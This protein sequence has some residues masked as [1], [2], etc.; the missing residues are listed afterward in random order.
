[1]SMP[2]CQAKCDALPGCTAITTRAHAPGLVDCYRKADVVPS[3]CD[4]GTSF[5]TYLRPPSS[6]RA[7]IAADE[8]P[9]FNVVANGNNID[10]LVPAPK[11]NGTGVV[12]LGEVDG[13]DACAALCVKRLGAASTTGVGGCTAFT[14]HSPAFDGPSWRR[15]CYGTT[16]GTWNPQGQRNITSGQSDPT[17]TRSPCETDDDCSR[18]GV[19]GRDGRCDCEP[20]WVGRFCTQLN[21]VPTAPGAGLHRH[22]DGQQVSTWGGSVLWDEDSKLWHSWNAEMVDFCGIRVWLTN[23]AIR[24]ATTASLDEP[25]E[26]KE[27]VWPVFAHEPTVAR[28]PTGE[29]VMFFTAVFAP[30]VPCTNRTCAGGV[31]GSTPW[32]HPFPG[33]CPN[34]Q[35]CDVNVPL[36]SY[37]SYS[38]GPDGPWS[39]PQILPAPGGGDTNL[40]PIIRKDGSL[41]GLGRPPFVWRSPDWKN[42]S[43]Y[44]FE[45][46]L[47]PLKNEDP[48][49]FVK[50]GD[51]SILHAVFH[52]GGWESPFG[53]HFW[54]T[55]DGHSWLGHNDVQTYSSAYAYAMREEEGG[56]RSV[57]VSRRERP[58]VV[59]DADG[60][61]QALTNGVTPTWPCDQPDNCP[62]D[63]CFTG[64]QRLAQ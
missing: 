64:L 57:S 44:S 23:S 31:N 30:T 53:Y 3:Q 45:Q 29:F 51:D 16:D 6:T 62:T 26:P 8:T 17:R 22:Q 48:F 1:M 5:D 27:M 41:L 35:H 15:Q 49:L 50:N 2:A 25:F 7:S 21:L 32:D 38:K 58:H 4:Q 14:W 61:P 54:S 20:Q 52:G 60:V 33:K 11:A 56:M 24:H 28:A 39:K 12:Y 19:C 36:S 55:D 46:V 59:L 10:G 37:M 43:A 9:R 18:N 13:A 63:Y 40:A 34:D 42:V 47:G